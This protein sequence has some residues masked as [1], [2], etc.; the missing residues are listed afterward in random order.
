MEI[1]GSGIAEEIAAAL[2]WWREAG[3][4]CAFEDVPRQW[5]APPVQDAKA[6]PVPVPAAPIAEPAM[7]AEAAIGGDPAVWPRELEGFRQWWITEPSL[8]GGRSGGRVAP[9]GNA[10]AALMVL[11]PEPEAEDGV[12]LLSGAQG[13]LLD[14]FLAAAGIGL[15]DAYVASALP[16]Y[17]PAAD[18]PALTAHGLGA[19][20]RH[21]VALVRPARLL[22][23]G[24][25]LLPLV[26]NDPANKADFS[27]RFNH[28]GI[29]LPLLGARDLQA[30]LQRPRGKAAVWRAW[31]DW[32]GG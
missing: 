20:V 19:V 24:S 13:R 3:V 10:G 11:V 30:L 1:S 4:D 22:V 25:N 26:D 14:G 16:R 23:F 27:R 21:H 18:W 17:T 7:P 2:E 8:D 31:L 15:E 32:T 6:P 12:R 5:L 28:E 9:R 29:S